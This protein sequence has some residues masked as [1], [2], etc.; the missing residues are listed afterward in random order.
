MISL[1]F[2]PAMILGVPIYF[3]WARGEWAPSILA[4]GVFLGFWWVQTGEDLRSR[5]LQSGV[6]R[7]L[8]AVIG[9]LWISYIAVG[10]GLRAAGFLMIPFWARPI[11][12]IADH[13]SWLYLISIAVQSAIWIYVLERGVTDAT[14]VEP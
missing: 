2:P 9:C 13:I 10:L 11:R 12:D 8:V 7:R 14:H 3:G 1:V 5:A 6:G 4:V